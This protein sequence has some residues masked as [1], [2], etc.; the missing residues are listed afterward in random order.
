MNKFLL[1]IVI[2]VTL[3]SIVA[4]E[5]NTWTIVKSNIDNAF[6]SGPSAGDIRLG[7]VKPGTKVVPLKRCEDY[8]HVKF[9]DGQTGWVH[10][11]LL[12]KTKPIERTLAQYNN[13]KKE[14]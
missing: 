8:Y 13:K 9:P 3:N 14:Q 2:I 1:I 10:S 4:A 12:K 11:V 5:D 6:W 7:V